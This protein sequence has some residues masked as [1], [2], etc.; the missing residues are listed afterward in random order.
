MYLVTGGTT[1]TFEEPALDSTEIL[2]DRDTRWRSGT[3]LPWPLVGV[4]AAS[5]NNKIIVF[6]KKTLIIYMRNDD[7]ID[8]IF[9]FKWKLWLSNKPSEPRKS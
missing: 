4:R 8:G 9:K 6:G 3:R 1:S 2:V 7:N 5:F